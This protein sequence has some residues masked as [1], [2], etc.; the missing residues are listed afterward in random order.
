[1]KCICGNDKFH[2]HQQCYHDV[3]VDG[4]NIFLD[5]RGCY[6]SEKPYGPYTCTACGKQYEELKT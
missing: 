6:D 4:N 3:T 1:M 2:A 5:D